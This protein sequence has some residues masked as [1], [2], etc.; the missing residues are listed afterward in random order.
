MVIRLDI[1]YLIYYI[2]GIIIAFM[3]INNIVDDTMDDDKDAGDIALDSGG[4][5]DEL[6]IKLGVIDYVPDIGIDNIDAVC[7]DDEKININAG[8]NN[9]YNITCFEL[10]N[11][12]SN[13]CCLCC[14]LLRKKGDCKINHGKYVPVRHKLP[15]KLQTQLFLHKQIVPHSDNAYVC[16]TCVKL[17]STEIKKLS[18]K[19]VDKNYDDNMNIIDKIKVVKTKFDLSKIKF[20]K[21]AKRVMHEAI[22]Q[23]KQLGKQTI[24]AFANLES[25]L[26]KSLCGVSTEQV[27]QISVKVKQKPQHL[28][29]FFYICRSGISYV[30][31]GGIFGKTAQAICIVFN[32]VLKALTKHF[33]SEH[34]GCTAFTRDTVKN[35]HTPNWIKK[36]HPKLVLIAD[37]TYIYT[38]KPTD[39]NSQRL[40]WG[41][42]KKR[43]FMRFMGIQLPDGRWFDMLGPFPGKRDDEWTWNYIV[44]KDIGGVASTF[45]LKEDVVM[46]DRGFLYCFKGDKHF[47]DILT[48]L[49]VKKG[50]KGQ[51]TAEDANQTRKVTS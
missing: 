39:F 31:A 48:P 36:L 46:G 32:K 50:N 38:E 45:D 3:D 17:T 16:P 18:V 5:N 1:L 34:L 7:I 43:H 15:A 30:K 33:V 2:I 14:K 47:S 37:G 9:F 35:K 51:M 49:T 24:L 27:L 28:F 44:E 21:L 6:G 26:C 40:L 8:K 25:N 20:Q 13:T 12:K 11:I 29:E 42:Y 4:F 22:L 23:A 41:E 10:F 19:V